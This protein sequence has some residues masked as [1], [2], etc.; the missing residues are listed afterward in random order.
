[1]L[2]IS[3]REHIRKIKQKKYQTGKTVFVCRGT[4]GRGRFFLISNS[5]EIFYRIKNMLRERPHSLQKGK[6]EDD[7]RK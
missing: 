2:K 1:M 5:A 7:V 3:F 6:K 4:G